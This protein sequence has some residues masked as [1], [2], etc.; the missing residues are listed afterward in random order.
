MHYFKL[1]LK[2][3]AAAHK[4]WQTEGNEI[5]IQLRI[6]SSILNMVITSLK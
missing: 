6:D 4:T 5:I 1:H 3:A 2:D